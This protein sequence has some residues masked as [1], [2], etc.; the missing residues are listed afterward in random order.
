[1]KYSRLAKKAV[2]LLLAIGMAGGLFYLFTSTARGA[3]PPGISAPGAYP[4]DPH[5][6]TEWE[7]EGVGVADIQAAFNNAR[8]AENTQLGSQVPA[9]ALPDQSTWDS[10]SDGEK[11]LWLIN[12]ERIDRGVA[13]LHGLEANV[14]AVAQTYA[15]YLLDND[16]WGHDANGQDPWQRLDGNPAIGACHDFLNVAEN[17]YVFVSTA[18][19]IALPIEQ[20]VYGWMYDD[21]G[22]GWGHRHAILWYPYDD[23]SGPAGREGFLGIGRASGGPY[24]GPFEHSWNHAELV[25]MNVFDPCSSWD[26][27]STPTNTF[28]YLP[29]ALKGS[30]GSNPTTYSI[31]GNV[32]DD[33]GTALQGVTIADGAGHTATTNAAGDYTLSGLAAGAYTLTPTLGGYTFTPGSLSIS[34]PP[35]AVAQ[36]FVG[37]ATATAN[38]RLV[39]FE[40]F[41]RD[42]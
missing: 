35:N 3:A 26:Y 2:G 41:F 7:L 16:A 31:A 9:L 23:N 6:D 4:S 8:T 17:L 11:A 20:A 19:P 36:N 15:Q 22:S 27:G 5:A 39:V 10:M 24:Q 18:P 32:V 13:P 21:S 25:V 14:T 38:E 28:V 33:H 40:A 42:T 30:G 29:V 34:L 37:T 12:R 1:M